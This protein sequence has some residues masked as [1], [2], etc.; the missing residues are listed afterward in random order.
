VKI[1]FFGHFGTENTG[2]ESTLMTAHSSLSR[3]A[4]DSE[5]LCICS[6]PDLVTAREGMEAVPI[7]TRVVR[8]WRHQDGIRWDRRLITAFVAVKEEL[9]E[10]VRAFRSLK[11]TDVLIIS[12][13]GLVTDAYGLA[14]WGP[15][16]Q[17]KWAL[18]AKLRRCKVVFLSVGVGPVHRAL[19]RILVRA[20]LRL[21]DY[22][23]YRDDASL[24]YLR[25]MHFRAKRDRVYPDLV[26][27]LPD[28]LLPPAR[29]GDGPRR[30]VVGLGLMAYVG[31]YNVPDPRF[32]THRRYLQSLAVFVEWL[33]AHDYDVR[34]LLGDGDSDIVDEL[35]SVLRERLGSYDETRVVDE[36]I[37][38]VR[39]VLAQIAATDV[40]VATRF[41]NV[42]LAMVL[43]KPVI[44]ISFHHKCDALMDQMR[45]SEYRHDLNRMDPQAL[46]EQFET[47]ERNRVDVKRTLDEGVESAR[48]ALDEQ[49]DLLLAGL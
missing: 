49:Y 39:D 34:L 21:A 42:L 46:I 18:M 22:R 19:G 28:A 36:P 4:P 29:N 32:E 11:G 17:F 24:E 47:L 12:G 20:S 5:F 14:G 23:S 33:V 15:Y 38:S 37:E 3:L 45:L 6:H 30:R 1:S 7:N 43:G 8:I 44:A 27:G 16:N 40:V 26:F 35:R 48:K 25:R 31:R 41:H 2:N 13:T 10:Y 9:R